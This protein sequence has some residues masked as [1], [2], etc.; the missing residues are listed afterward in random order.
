MLKKTLLVM[1]AVVGL[2]GCA[3]QYMDSAST[4][5]G[6]RFVVGAWDNK[7]AVFHCPDKPGVGD[8]ERIDVELK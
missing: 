6:G 1:F 7:R 4:D 3:T 8:C 2:G 5:H